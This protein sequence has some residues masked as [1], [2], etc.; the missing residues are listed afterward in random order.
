MKTT[1]DQLI[2][3]SFQVDCTIE[4]LTYGYSWRNLAAA[5]AVINLA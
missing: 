2:M 5:V 1:A 4:S 3:D